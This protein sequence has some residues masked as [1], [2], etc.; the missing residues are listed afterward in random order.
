[1]LF[2]MPSSYVFYSNNLNENFSKKTNFSITFFLFMFFR[3]IRFREVLVYSLQS[4]HMDTLLIIANIDKSTAC[5]LF[6]L[7]LLFRSRY[8]FC[9]VL[10][11]SLFL[12]VYELSLE[13]S[14]VIYNL[15]WDKLSPKQLI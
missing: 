15:M 4:S 10:L 11:I 13:I 3:T 9:F 12:S 2:F 1:M 14:F 6:F 5:F 7:F 8:L